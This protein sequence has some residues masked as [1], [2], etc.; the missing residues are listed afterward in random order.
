M[1][2][3]SAPKRRKPGKQNK[4]G[5]EIFKVETHTSKQLRHF[6]YRTIRL[7]LSWCTSST[8]LQQVCGHGYIGLFVRVTCGSFINRYN[9][10]VTC[11][12]CNIRCFVFFLWVFLGI[13][14]N[15][16]TFLSSIYY[17]YWCSYFYRLSLGNKYFCLPHELLFKDDLLKTL[18]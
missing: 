5:V 2:L 6:K 1:F 12:F 17:N 13:L 11:Y 14:E 16:Q 15:L 3:E 4:D 10:M 7:L 9:V 18:V 8:L